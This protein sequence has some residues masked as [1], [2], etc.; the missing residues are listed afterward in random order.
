MAVRILLLNIFISAIGLFYLTGPVFFYN[1]DTVFSS[2]IF[3]LERKAGEDSIFPIVKPVI[4][5]FLGNNERNFYKK[6]NIS[7]RIGMAKILS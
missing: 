1:P 4:P 3:P 6:I 2:S 5:T 7:K